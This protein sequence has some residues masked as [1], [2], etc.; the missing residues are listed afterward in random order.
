M[1]QSTLVN[2]IRQTPQRKWK[3][4]A[5][6]QKHKTTTTNQQKKKHW[7]FIYHNAF[8]LFLDSME[9]RLPVKTTG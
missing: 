3:F 9:K 4:E 1:M 2:S 5:N 7:S 8:I 6:E